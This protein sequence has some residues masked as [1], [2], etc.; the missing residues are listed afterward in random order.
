MAK[1]KNMGRT[2]KRKSATTKV[3][4]PRSDNGLPE[5]L[6]SN[7]SDTERRLQERVKELNCLYEVQELLSKPEITPEEICQGI[8]KAIPPGWQFPDVCRAIIT[9]GSSTF[10]SNFFQNH[11][12]KEGMMVQFTA[13]L[14]GFYSDKGN[15]F[16][17]TD[18]E[19]FD[20][21]LLAFFEDY[22]ADQESINR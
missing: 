22:M 3:S 12:K 1:S 21:D 16:V 7:T 11:H 19:S 6:P 10:Q 13:G 20:N 14:P 9:F 2:P 4:K 8:V 18:S 5:H 17:N 15:G